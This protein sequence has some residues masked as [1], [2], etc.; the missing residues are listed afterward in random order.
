VKTQSVECTLNEVH[1]HEDAECGAH[2]HEETDVE[3]ND[4]ATCET[5]N[6]CVVEEYFS[7]LGVS[8]T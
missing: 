7:E 6:D 5:C 2:K 4:I 3:S 8:K 1:K